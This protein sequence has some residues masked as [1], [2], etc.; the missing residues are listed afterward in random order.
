MVNML[1]Q[2][3][4]KIASPPDADQEDIGRRRLSHLE[5]LDRLRE[6]IDKGIRS[7]E[8]GEGKPLDTAKFLKAK[9]TPNGA[10]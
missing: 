1:D 7:L 3:I 6:E 5:K 9:H 4:A 2:A 10:S 8:G